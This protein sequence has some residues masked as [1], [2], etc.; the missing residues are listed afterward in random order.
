MLK[1]KNLVPALLLV[2]LLM[3]GCTLM[4]L[5]R[6][7]GSG[8]IAERTY[9]LT[10]FTALA[11]ANSFAVDVTQGDD[12]SVHVSAD[13][14]ILEMVIARVED[15]TLHLEL[16]GGRLYSATELKA[17]VTMPALASIAMSGASNVTLAGF[18]SQRGFAASVSG[19]SVLEGEIGADNVR[20]D[21]TGGS[22]ITL[23]GEGTSLAASISGGSNVDL[24]VFPVENASLNLA[25]GSNANVTV[26]GR[27]N[28]AAS[29][30][31][32]VTYGGGGRVGSS[33]LSG[34]SSISER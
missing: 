16:P 18:V 15:G 6:I 5:E 12:Y 11:I 20:L 31:S 33:T 23:H 24:Q 25:G 9:D 13:D 3:G 22:R 26:T 8:T 32:Q 34:A 1:T 17:S 10:G 28:V 19:A 21:I 7:V 14:N 4:P 2:A 29:G 30:A 27:L